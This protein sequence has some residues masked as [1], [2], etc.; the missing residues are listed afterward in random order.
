MI[1]KRAEYSQ[2]QVVARV[3][4]LQTLA[5]AFETP[6]NPGD[7]G[8]ALELVQALRE[9]VGVH[10]AADELRDPLHAVEEAVRSQTAAEKPA[11]EHEFTY[12]FRR[13]TK[14]PLTEGSYGVDLTFGKPREMADIGAFHEAFGFRVAPDSAVPPD[15]VSV[16]LEFVALLCIKEAYAVSCRWHEQAEITRQARAHYLTDHLTGWLPVFRR[17]LEQHA[18][19]PYFPSLA[20]L[21]E[22][23]VRWEHREVATERPRGFDS[24]LRR[25]GEVGAGGTGTGAGGL[26]NL[27]GPGVHDSDSSSFPCGGCPATGWQA[28]HATQ[29]AQPRAKQAGPVNQTRPAGNG[30]ET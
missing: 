19:V 9:A 12:L 18:R 21:A 27:Q 11:I 17:R 28:G 6:E 2:E 22:A 3:Q 20:G 30:I 8:A 7:G 26:S 24:T 14:V 4:L 25:P 5:R 23:A 1:E 29:A 13:K 16:Q 10:P 15:H